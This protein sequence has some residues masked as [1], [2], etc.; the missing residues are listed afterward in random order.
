M[1]TLLYKIGAVLLAILLAI[2][3]YKLWEHKQQQIGAA[4][5]RAADAEQKIEGLEK[6]LAVANSNA[7]ETQRRLNAQKESQNVANK[8]AA[9]A[10]ADAVAASAAASS[11]RKQLATYVAAHRGGAPRDPAPGSVSKSQPGA[12]PL[13]LLSEL[14]SRSDEAA[15]DIAKYADQ[16]RRAGGQCERDSDALNSK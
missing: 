2:G 16:L 6:G 12:D 3:G 9:Q 10:R 13:D 4:T 15:G 11:L 14:Y 8:A 7:N 1:T 5:Q